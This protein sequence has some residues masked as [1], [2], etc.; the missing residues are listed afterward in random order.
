MTAEIESADSIV[1]SVWENGEG[2][3]SQANARLIAA[4]PEMY[5]LLSYLADDTRST[6]DE[7]LEM[8]T[9]AKSL[10]NRINNV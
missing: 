7:Q 5:E 8:I 6:L 9:K 1:C 2:E 4:A 10:L 3:I